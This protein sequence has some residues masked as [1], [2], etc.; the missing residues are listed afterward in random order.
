MVNKLRLLPAIL[1]FA[2]V[3]PG[4]AQTAADDKTAEQIRECTRANFPVETSMQTLELA[5]YD[6]SGGKRVLKSK[7]F[8][9]RMPNGF[10]RAMMQVSAPVDL[11][12]SS[13]LVIERA[14]IDDMYIYLPNVRKAR[15]IVGQTGGKPL[16]NTDF[17]YEDIKQMQG[18]TKSGTV[19]RL[20]DVDAAS[21]KAYVLEI[22]PDSV[23][24]SSYE[25]IVAQIDQTTCTP[26]QIEFYESGRVLRKRLTGDPASLLQQ[27]GRWLL[28]KLEMHD[29]RDD[30]R[31][32]V[33]IDKI[34]YN[35]KLADTVFNPLRFFQFSGR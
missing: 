20:P 25:T 27:D 13:Y 21:R 6:R 31:T 1:A 32:T 4:L 26:L 11:S 29:L 7:L 12:G 10:S 19:K 3:T 5:A 2:C 9:K 15:R 8:W 14:D 34:E 17:S 22:T 33:Q 30:T 28:R 18:V 23:A 24:Q 16:W 35:E